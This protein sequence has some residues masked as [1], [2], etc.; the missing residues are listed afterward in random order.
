MPGFRDRICQL[1]A[2][3]C[4]VAEHERGSRTAF[5]KLIAD[6]ADPLDEGVGTT[7]VSKWCD[8][9]TVPSARHLAL[10]AQRTGVSVDWLLGLE[11][12]PMMRGQ[13][14]GE[15]SL[16]DDVMAHLTRAV[17]QEYP[18]EA[19]SFP[20]PYRWVLR[21]EAVWPTILAAFRPIVE[22]QSAT[23]QHRAKSRHRMLRILD[24]IQEQ[25]PSAFYPGI[26]NDWLAMEDRDEKRSALDTLVELLGR[27]MLTLLEADPNSDADPIALVPERRAPMDANEPTEVRMARH[28]APC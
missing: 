28:P 21:R 22:R 25:P 26:S 27:E 23:K 16:L 6:P 4:P 24:A 15:A 12:A 14:R 8:G 18:P 19:M 10:L 13:S 11:G 2:S 17:T 9:G 20:E 3:V 5:A 1:V 7:L